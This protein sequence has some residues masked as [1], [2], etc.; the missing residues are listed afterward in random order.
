MKSLG[1]LYRR[2]SISSKLQLFSMATTGLA[3]FLVSAFLIAHEFRSYQNAVT[4]NLTA[5]ARIVASNGSA[6]VVFKDRKAAAEIL[7]S[8]AT[9]PDIVKAEI[10]L[11][12]DSVF[13]TFNRSAEPDYPLLAKLSA[14]LDRLHL[15]RQLQV[16]EDILVNDDRVGRL[17]LVADLRGLY[18]TIV[19]YTLVTLTAAAMALILATLLLRRLKS[20]ITGPLLN[21]TALMRRVSTDRDYTMRSDIDSHD[22]V[23]DLAR[24][25]N[26]MLGQIQVREHNLQ[27]ELAERKRAEQRLDRLAHFDT[28][29]GL[30]NRYSF[31]ERLTY[32][33]EKAEAYGDR[34]GVMFIDLDNFK[35]IND[36]LGHHIGDLLLA[37]V[38]KRLFSVLRSRDLIFRIGGDE[39]A[40]LLESIGD[41][42]NVEYVAEKIIHALTRPFSLEDHEV[43]VS[44]SIGISFC[45]DD[46]R[47][48][49]TLLKCADTAMYH[50][51]ERGKNTYQFFQ[52]EMNGKALVR[53]NL[54][55]GLRRALDKNEFVLFYQPQYDLST[56]RTSGVEALVRWRHPEMGLISPGEFIPV[57][58]DSGLIIPLGE[59]ILRTACEQGAVWQKQCAY[60]PIISVNLSGRQFKDDNLVANVTQIILET[61]LNPRLLELELT[62]STLMDGS[63][64]TLN[65]LAQFRSLGIRLSIDDFGTG[66]SSMSYLKRFPINQLK[67]DRSFIDGIPQ[68][69]EN[70]AIVRAI[71]ALGRSLDIDLVAEGVEQVEQAEFLKREHCSCIQGYLF[72]RPLTANELTLLLMRE[73]LELE[74]LPRNKA[75]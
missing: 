52:A 33:L 38:G 35:I 31:N 68:N 57:A 47:D 55:T 44:A 59:W 18:S 13:A 22:E 5:Q 19:H 2:L 39:F 43:F 62:E 71:I 28:V 46:A 51:K 65:K 7:G 24:G 53:L 74:V 32:A 41:R 10:R 30:R 17:E 3:L 1:L 26:D 29:T 67:I 36:T 25:F 60:P 11:P 49:A 73:T 61:G 27:R 21:L 72:S 23:G 48:T 64:A 66:Y 70:A 42:Y 63:S 20:S 50:A 9:S 15:P 34:T 12:D 8:L 40:L 37:G 56:S 16:R 6:A 45:P 69:K 75:N 4:E 54:E 58:E 14:Y